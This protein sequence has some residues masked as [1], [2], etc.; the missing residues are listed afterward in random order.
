MTTDGATIQVPPGEIRALGA[1]LAAQGEEAAGVAGRLDAAAPVGRAL[2]A[3]AE[4]FL[5]CH[6]AA[7]SALAGELHW[8]GRTVA[9][10][11]DSWEGLDAALLVRPGRPVPR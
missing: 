9:A 8:L 10:V 2:Q 11:A 6:R 3:A 5:A 1:A 7:A 4:D